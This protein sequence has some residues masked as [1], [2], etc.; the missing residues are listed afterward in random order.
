MAIRAGDIARE[1]KL[2]NRTPSVCSA[3][4]SVSFLREN[5]AVLERREGP[6]RSTT[7]VFHYRLEGDVPLRESEFLG[8]RGAGKEAFA[9]LGG[10][11][12]FIREER[13]S[14]YR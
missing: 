6:E 7:T 8:L 11:E 14:F 9:E 2:V 13:E 4:E 12:K 10:A 1:L 5:H 3:L